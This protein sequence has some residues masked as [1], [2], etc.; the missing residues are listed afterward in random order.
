MRGIIFYLDDT[1]FPREQFLRSGFA[2]VAQYIADSWR[3]DQPA[4]LETLLHAHGSGRDGQ[5]FQALCEQWRLPL[6]LVPWL[7][8]LFRTHTPAIALD[9]LATATLERLRRDGWRLVIMTNG[10]PSVQRRKV[11]ALALETLVDGVVYAEEHAP[12]REMDPA[13]FLAAMAHLNVPGPR[14]VCVGDDP[15]SE[16]AGARRAGLK[17]IRIV[18]PMLLPGQRDDADAVLQ[19]LVSL[20]EVADAL[21][22]ESADAA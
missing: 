12:R 10:D 22:P 3:R 4:V 6:S 21:I 14:C 15:A 11:A 2:V 1:L 19:S 17:S 9:P 7:V 5:E 20:P 16:V 13:A 18:G 8:A